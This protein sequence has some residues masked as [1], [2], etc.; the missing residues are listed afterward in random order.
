MKVLLFLALG[1]NA[2]AYPV[3]TAVDDPTF[4]GVE[5][6][7]AREHLSKLR[8]VDFDRYPELEP[9]YLKL[10]ALTEKLLIGKDGTRPIRLL[11]VDDMTPNAFW[12][13]TG[14][15]GDRVLGIHLGLLKLADTDDQVAYVLGHELEHGLSVLNNPSETDTNTE[16]ARHALLKRVAEN[17]V[18]VKS[19]FNRVHKKGMNPYAAREMMHKIREAVGDDVPGRTHTMWANRINTVEQELTGMTRI[20]GENPTE[21]NS[22]G[23][24]SPQVKGFL[25]SDGFLRRRRDNVEAMMAGYGDRVGSLLA[26]VKSLEGL[27]EDEASQA[28][29]RIKR[30]HRALLG[31]LSLDR[32][33]IDEELYGLLPEARLLDYRLRHEAAFARTLFEGIAKAFGEGVEA[34]SLGQFEILYH[35]TDTDKIFGN[36]LMAK[37]YSTSST[38]L[39]AIDSE[40]ADEASYK[41][42]S[43]EERSSRR[44]TIDRKTR[45]LEAR[46][47]VLES[48]LT[49]PSEAKR[50]ASRLE[51]MGSDPASAASPNSGEALR[52]E[53]NGYIRHVDRELHRGDGL[54]QTMALSYRELYSSNPAG[55]DLRI[56]AL[57]YGDLPMEKQRESLPY[58]FERNIDRI[59]KAI[60]Q[61]ENQTKDP[62]YPDRQLPK[63]MSEF[64]GNLILYSRPETY[65]FDDYVSDN[66]EHFTETMRR[67]YNAVLDHAT[68]ARLIDIFFGPPA[69]PDITEPLSV[70]FEPQDRLSLRDDLYG[71]IIDDTITRR[72][73]RIR[74]DF[75]YRELE[76]HLRYG[77]LNSLFRRHLDRQFA[78]K[79]ARIRSADTATGGENPPV[80]A[81]PPERASK[82]I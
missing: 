19:I 16:N 64:R 55:A 13:F 48:G 18:D 54:K 81:M 22:N 9:V 71:Q 78:T 68:D 82:N 6:P 80:S 20:I 34:R 51:E 62:F 44:A 59:I 57:F 38:P 12:M 26:S 52:R 8:R 37:R 33:R 65:G 66:P 7:E 73:S 29:Q 30:E 43:P 21:E 1:T 4:S 72:A 45:A 50:I 67:L 35:L 79:T 40:I 76:A 36:P 56:A 74:F 5:K 75:L 31:S 24:L 14:S 61:R 39:A 42:D 46:R 17:E 49:N 2:F 11:F 41:G 69:K 25:A 15:G 58:L 27:P 77:D 60:V 3:V 23:I 47:R 53:F 70:T 63:A 28:Q 32:R 10:I